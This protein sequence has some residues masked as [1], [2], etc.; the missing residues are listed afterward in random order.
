MTADGRT[1]G[2]VRGSLPSQCGG[3]QDAPHTV[4]DG[5]DVSRRVSHDRHRSASAGAGTD[6]RET[7]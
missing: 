6:Q 1:F 5:V 2:Q 4:D 7:A 3:T